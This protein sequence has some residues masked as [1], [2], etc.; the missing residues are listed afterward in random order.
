MKLDAMPARNIISLF[1]G[2][3]DFYYWKGLPCARRWPRPQKQPGTADQK[4]TWLALKQTHALI[5]QLP[6]SLKAIWKNQTVPPRKTVN[7]L[8]RRNCLWSLAAGHTPAMPLV[9]RA[10]LEL[11]GSAPDTN[12]WIYVD[13][14]DGF[15][16]ENC[17]FLYST[18]PPD[19]PEVLH[20]RKASIPHGRHH[21]E[22]IDY[23]PDLH[24]WQ[25]PDF[26]WYYQS[27]SV[28]R[29]FLEAKQL[30][31]V[32]LLPAPPIRRT[33]TLQP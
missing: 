24:G 28:Y 25:T 17:I 11:S 1:R 30:T 2:Q 32:N 19:G 20:Y 12:I 26:V 29:L 23:F 3:V 22:K 16:P 5:R 33:V 6:K 10:T 15:T 8:M 14:Y 31:S 9:T 7:D 18:G 21:A 4:E 13:P 27:N